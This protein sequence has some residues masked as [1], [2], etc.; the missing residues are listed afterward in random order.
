MRGD[1]V[2]HYTISDYKGQAAWTQ[3]GHMPKVNPNITMSS[4]RTLYVI[5]IFDNAKQV[6]DNKD[7]KK[8]SGLN[9]RI[10]VQRSWSSSAAWAI[11]STQSQLV[12]SLSLIYS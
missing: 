6:V 3:Y 8:S 2:S 10:R 12:I 11:M 7:Y 4:H 5:C 9:E 1:N